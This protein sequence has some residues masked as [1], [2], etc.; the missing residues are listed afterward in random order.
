MS[1]LWCTRVLGVLNKHTFRRVCI[2][3]F[4]FKFSKV[5]LFGS[6]KKPLLSIF[7]LIWTAAKS[8]FEVLLWKNEKP[9]L[10]Q[11]YKPIIY[12]LDKPNTQPD[13]QMWKFSATLM[14]KSIGEN[15]KSM[16]TDANIIVSSEQ[17]Y[18]VQKNSIT[19]ANSS[20]FHKSWFFCRFIELI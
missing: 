18:K 1:P 10:K 11:R 7:S 9:T 2:N 17:T 13:K 3:L 16:Q 20:S 6:Y 14:A 5:F 12:V 4:P 15:V 19:E 8:S